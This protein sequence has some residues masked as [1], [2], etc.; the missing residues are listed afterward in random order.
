MPYIADVAL[1][2][3]KRVNGKIRA[4][5]GNSWMR[6]ARKSEMVGSCFENG[7]WW[8]GEIGMEF[9]VGKQ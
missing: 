8:M 5:R 9:W 7:W 3:C 4:E 2:L 1:Q 6:E